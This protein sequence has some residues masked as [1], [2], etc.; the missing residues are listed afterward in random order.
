[1]PTGFVSGP[2]TQTTR[3][4]P[5]S[6]TSKTYRFPLGDTSG[7]IG[8]PDSLPTCWNSFVGWWAGPW[9]LGGYLEITLLVAGIA[10]QIGL[11]VWF[12]IGTI[13]NEVDHVHEIYLF[14]CYLFM[15]ILLAAQAVPWLIFVE[16]VL[17][18]FTGGN[19]LV[20]VKARK[21]LLL[22]LGAM[23]P[24][25]LVFTAV[26]PSIDGSAR[27]NYY[28]MAA[29]PGFLIGWFFGLTYCTLMAI[30]TIDYPLSQFGVTPLVAG[31]IFLLTSLGGAGLGRIF[32][33]ECNF[34]EVPNNPWAGCHIAGAGNSEPMN[35]PCPG[36]SG[37]GMKCNCPFADDC[38]INS[39]CYNPGGGHIPS[40]CK[41]GCMG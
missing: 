29:E 6:I 2:W 33:E 10:T 16:P 24:A 5:N 22:L 39:D 27:Q 11:M 23:V 28:Y 17:V 41:M 19:N 13:A 40:G 15:C 7:S 8:L 14:L 26:I 12:G 25:I 36:G 1:M 34:W 18:V 30:T 3:G 37:P 31:V 35:C 21:P 9:S 20:T 38:T 32:M 4:V